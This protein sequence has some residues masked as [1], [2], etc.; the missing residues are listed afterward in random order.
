MADIEQT[1]VAVP[2]GQMHLSSEAI[3][4]LI[5][6]QAVRVIAP[7]GSGRWL[8]ITCDAPF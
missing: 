8:T 6:R 5:K 3:R 4:C 2:H 1:T 7:D